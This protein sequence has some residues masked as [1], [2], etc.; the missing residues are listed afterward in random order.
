[1]KVARAAY[2]VGTRTI[3]DLLQEQSALFQIQQNYATSIYQ[4]ITDSLSM[5]K[6]S[7]LISM[8]DIAAINNLASK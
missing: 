6:I 1:M 2:A 7:G 5:K 3:V 4:Y 8:K